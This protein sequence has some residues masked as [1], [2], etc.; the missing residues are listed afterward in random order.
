MEDGDPHEA[1]AITLGGKENYS[2]EKRKAAKAIN[3]GLIY[4]KSAKSFAYD[5]NVSEEEAQKY[6]DDY[7]NKLPN[8]KR[9]LNSCVREA[10]QT[11]MI[12]NIYGRK[13]R[14]HKYI[15]RWGNLEGRGK[16]IC[17]NF[18]IQ[19]MGAEVTK[20]ALI[21]VYYG[22]IC[23]KDYEG[24]VYFRNTIHDE[25]NTSVDF[26]VIEDV[27]K[28]LG[29]LMTHNIPNT[30]VPIITGLEIGHSMGLT[31]KFKQ[32]PI[33]LKLTPIIYSSIDDEN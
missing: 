11:K 29:D 3:F 20:M 14:L 12:S 33:T 18:P 7:F 31:W 24:K 13:R 27:V 26:S 28:K 15:D 4:G 2:K 21:K 9:F 10:T 17:Y 16:R 19:S 6:V 22:I 8:V 1:T 30:P 32:D 25:I 23:N 5:L